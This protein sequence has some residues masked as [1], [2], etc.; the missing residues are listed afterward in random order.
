MLKDIRDCCLCGR[1]RFGLV[2]WK[3]WRAAYFEF[4]EREF[5][6][7]KKPVLLFEVLEL[8]NGK[9]ERVTEYKENKN[10]E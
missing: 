6:W 1:Q 10:A 4:L 2:Y 9:T 5:I 8:I 3:F 7:L